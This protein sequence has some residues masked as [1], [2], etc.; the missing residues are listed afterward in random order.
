MRNRTEAVDRTREN[1]QIATEWLWS[2]LVAL[3][4]VVYYYV[5]RDHIKKNNQAIIM[6]SRAKRGDLD[7]LLRRITPRNDNR[8]ASPA[9]G[10]IAMTEKCNS[11]RELLQEGNDVSFE[12]QKVDHPYAF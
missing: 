10:G 4:F 1:K 2:C 12:T 9:K 7:R 8:I 11:Q 5:G 6:S 3:F